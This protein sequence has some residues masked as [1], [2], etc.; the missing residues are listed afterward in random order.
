M[1]RLWIVSLV[2]NCS[3]HVDVSTLILDLVV[4]MSLDKIG[5]I[6]RDRW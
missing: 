6:D 4:G 3:L 1:V 2:S 5:Q